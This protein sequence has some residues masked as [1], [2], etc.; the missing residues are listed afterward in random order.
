MRLVKPSGEAERATQTTLD[1]I[2]VTKKLAASWK[3]PPFQRELRPTPRV[4]ALADDIKKSGVLPGILTLG[5]LDGDIFIV[6]GQ[7][8]LHAFLVSD[9][10]V[11]YADVRTHYFTSM[12]EMAQEYVLLNSS[13]VRL[14]PDDILKGLEQSNL[15]LQRIRKRC[16]YVG[17]DAVRRGA[18]SPVLSMSTLLRMW[19]GSR[20]DV[21]SGGK[22]SVATIADTLND[23]DTDELI[24][25]VGLCFAGWRRDAEYR[26]LWGSLNLTLC[27]WLY[28]R[29][30][31]G[32]AGRGTSRSKKLDAD[33]FRRCLLA[34]SA[35]PAYLEYLV[36]RRISDRDRA[37]TYNR[38]KTIFAHRYWED[39]KEK[40]LLPS[41]AWAHQS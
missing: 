3:S 38:L 5:V 12:G 4:L 34:L 6:D 37:P 36:G 17:Y 22:L 25:F 2:E 15:H 24:A 26:T 7:H 39:R 35:T 20:P 23:Q 27:S 1:T 11:A 28:R 21:P 32:E 29:V 8:R 31:I 16:P 9:A 41:P 10:L 14:R 40:L 13:L 33:Q 30:V 18:T 19:E